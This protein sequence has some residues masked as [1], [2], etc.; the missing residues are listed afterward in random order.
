MELISYLWEYIVEVF[1]LFI[2]YVFAAIFIFLVL[3][4]F[5]SRKITAAL[6]AIFIGVSIAFYVPHG[7]PTELAYPL[8]LHSFGPGERPDLPIR[9]VFHFFQNFSNF[10]RV[11]DIARNPTDVPKTVL[12]S[13][14]GIVDVSLTTKE[15]IAEMADGTTINYWTFDGTVPGPFIRVQEGDTVRLTIH[16][17]ET[18][19]HP[20]NV[21]FHAVTGPGGGGA[22]TIVAPGETK[23]FTFKALNAG[24]FIYHCAYGNPGL[25]MTHGMYG[26]I[27]VEPKGGLPPVDEEFYVVQGE[28]YSEGRLGREGLQLFDT[29]SYLDGKP[30]YIVFNGKT[31]ALMDN[32]TAKVG[33]TVRIYVGNGGVNLISSF[34][35]IGEI[36]DRVYRE[37]DLVSPPAQNLQTTLIPAGGAAMVEFKVDYPGKYILVDHALSRVDRGAWGALHVEGEADSTIY[38]GVIQSG[39]G[40]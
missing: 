35:V 3:R 5:H 26:L 36:F 19:L 13:D 32:M 22:A 38:D 28:F 23:T 20:H 7:M 15:V 4:Q 17:D 31:G 10:E 40:H 25:H 18:S 1:G 34:H 6:V 12:Y 11:A 24:L 37:G 30:Q 8:S 29:Q 33:D 21:D 2:A 14:D 39:G 16:N 9:N 27:L